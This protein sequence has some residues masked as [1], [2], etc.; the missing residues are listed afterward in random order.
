MDSRGSLPAVACCGATRTQVRHTTGK[1]EAQPP[2]STARKKSSLHSSLLLLLRFFSPALGTETA[3][4]GRRPSSCA[5]DMEGISGSHLHASRESA[6]N[7]AMLAAAKSASRS[8]SMLAA[9]SAQGGA[10]SGSIGRKKALTQPDGGGTRPAG[11]PYHSGGLPGAENAQEEYGTSSD[12]EQPPPSMGPTF[13]LPN[14]SALP[15]RTGPLRRGSMNMSSPNAGRKALLKKS[16]FGASLREN[17]VRRMT[18]HDHVAIEKKRDGPSLNKELRTMYDP[19]NVV[20]DDHISGKEHMYSDISL[21][22]RESLKFHP[23]VQ[24]I[25]TMLWMQLDVENYGFISKERCDAARRGNG[26]GRGA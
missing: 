3:P 22:K 7:A 25:M 11:R 19:D 6:A 4:L 24:K 10:P 21:L 8:A 17:A 15:L 26:G 14:F 2:E 9:E 1:H 20:T 13:H 12:E 23:T 5:V 18:S 16:G